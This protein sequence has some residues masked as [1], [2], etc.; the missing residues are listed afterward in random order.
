MKKL[1]KIYFY[2]EFWLW[3]TKF[4]IETNI[5]LNSETQFLN[6][7]DNPVGEFQLECTANFLIGTFNWVIFVVVVVVIYINEN[8]SA[9]VKRLV[10]NR[11][12]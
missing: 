12:M 9:Y 6:R 2:S 3:P 8:C 7:F 4:R 11:D 5:E 1:S 10:Q